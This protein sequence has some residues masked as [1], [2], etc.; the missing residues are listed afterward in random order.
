MAGSSSSHLFHVVDDFYFSAL[1]DDDEIFP[2]SDEKYAHQLQLQEAL[3][4]A[5]ASLFQNASSSKKQ[6][7]EE[8][9]A[10]DQLHDSFCEICMDR[11]TASDMFRNINVCGHLFCLDCIRR[12]VAAKIKENIPQVKCPE[13]KCKGI[14]GPEICRSIVPKQVLAR[15][16]ESLCES[17]ILG[18]DKF[19][20]PFKDCSAMLVDDGG[21]TVTSSECPNCNRLFCAQ[22]RVV[23][24]SG[25]DCREF[26]SLEKGERDPEDVMLMELAKKKKWRRCPRCKFFVE[27]A[28]GA[29]MNFVMDAD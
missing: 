2:I 16:E 29:G 19:Y 13:P 18:S 8:E 10:S 7:I 6:R 26:Q 28:Q 3:I 12:H 17:L 22:C 27:K 1:H 24:H 14:I 20:C 23:W 21:E 9:D 11:K 5:S 25:M 4:S 15:W